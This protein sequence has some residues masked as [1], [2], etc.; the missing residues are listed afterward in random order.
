LSNKKL[1]HE[2][3]QFA[4]HDLSCDAEASFLLCM[5]IPM[6]WIT[7]HSPYLLNG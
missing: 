3:V 6:L 7:N 5:S 4:I 2:N 1:V